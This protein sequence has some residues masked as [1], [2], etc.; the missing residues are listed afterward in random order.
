MFLRALRTEAIL[1]CQW[2]LAGTTRSC[3]DSLHVPSP[4]SVR[5][6]PCQAVTLIRGRCTICQN[7]VD[8]KPHTIYDDLGLIPPVMKREKE[9]HTQTVSSN[10]LATVFPA[11]PATLALAQH[12]T[13]HPVGRRY[14][15]NVNICCDS[16]RVVPGS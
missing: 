4:L 3:I 8:D 11:D 10:N 13:N 9:C 2:G 12:Q 7:C 14:R 6:V 1:V 5:S 15:P 16:R